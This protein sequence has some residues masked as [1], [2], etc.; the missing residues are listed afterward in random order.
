MLERTFMLIVLMKKESFMMR[1]R[2]RGS[3]NSGG[4]DEPIKDR[5]SFMMLQNGNG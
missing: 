1:K 4:S 5:K 2:I 3:A